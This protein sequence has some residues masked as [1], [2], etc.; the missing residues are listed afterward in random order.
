MGIEV[1]PD[2]GRERPPRPGRPPP[3]GATAICSARWAGSVWF[4]RCVETTVT[5][6]PSRTTVTSTARRPPTRGWVESAP[7]QT[8]SPVGQ[9]HHGGPLERRRGTRRRSRAVRWCSP[10]PRTLPSRGRCP[11]RVRRTRSRTRHRPPE[12]RPARPTV[13]SLAVRAMPMSTSES[14]PSSA[15]ASSRR[16]ASSAGRRPRSRFQ[17]ATRTQPPSGRGAG[18]G[19][20]V[21]GVEAGHF[22]E[23]APV[24][25]SRRPAAPTRRRVRGPSASKA[26]L[27]ACHSEE[28]TAGGR[29][30][31]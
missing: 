11:A 20:C 1:T 6:T 8:S 12:R 9:A 19:R 3:R 21:D 15:P 7:N 17:A 31:G 23:Q 16:R 22:G 2:D 24:Q 13:S 10:H 26:R 18:G 14:R 4:S 29:A 30:A 28:P 27:G 25:R 5:A